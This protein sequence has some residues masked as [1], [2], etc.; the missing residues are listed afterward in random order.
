MFSLK[1]KG[2]SLPEA[3]QLFFPV[4]A[5]SHIWL[6]GWTIF[7]YDFASFAATLG[8]FCT[9]RICQRVKTVTLWH[10]SIILFLKH[11]KAEVAPN[12]LSKETLL[13]NKAYVTLQI[14]CRSACR[15]VE[16]QGFCYHF[17]FSIFIQPI[18]FNKHILL[19]SHQ[20]LELH[21]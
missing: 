4:V 8:I 14:N 2:V 9:F 21:S 12:W 20:L 6:K 10:C 16:A 5:L 7:S 3:F 19:H 1:T 11:P 13:E 18:A 15:T 17:P